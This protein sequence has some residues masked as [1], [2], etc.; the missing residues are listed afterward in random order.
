[1]TMTNKL[2]LSWEEET[3]LARRQGEEMGLEQGLEQGLEKGLKKGRVEGRSEGQ[4]K[5][6][7]ANLL[8]LLRAKFD[9]VPASIE[10]EVQGCSDLDALQRAC[11]Q[12]LSATQ[13]SDID[14]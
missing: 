12:V 14:L 13:P 10:E 1:M 11:V 9:G 7:R 8:Q 5:A 2:G 4:V 6:L 3:I